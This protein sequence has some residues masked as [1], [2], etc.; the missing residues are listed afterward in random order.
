MTTLAER[1]LAQVTRHGIRPDSTDLN[2]WADPPH[3]PP[4]MTPH[5]D[6]TADATNRGHGTIGLCRWHHWTVLGRPYDDTPASRE[7]QPR[8]VRP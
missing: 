1:V 8:L 7:C 5:Y 2:C 6:G 4:W 3:H